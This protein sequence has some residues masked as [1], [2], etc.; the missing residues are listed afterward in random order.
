M[1][2]WIEPGKKYPPKF[3]NVTKSKIG[4]VWEWGGNRTGGRVESFLPLLPLACWRLSPSHNSDIPPSPCL[5]SSIAPF[6]R[7]VRIVKD[8]ERI[9]WSKSDQSLW[10]DMNIDSDRWFEKVWKRENIIRWNKGNG[11]SFGKWDSPLSLELSQDPVIWTFAEWKLTSQLSV[12]EICHREPPCSHRVL[13]CFP[14]T[15]ISGF[16]EQYLSK[17]LLLKNCKIS[18]LS[19]APT[20]WLTSSALFSWLA[21]LIVLQTSQKVPFHD[22]FWKRSYSPQAKSFVEKLK[23]NH[24]II[25]KKR[26]H[27]C[28]INLFWFLSEIQ[29]LYLSEFKYHCYTL[30]IS[31]SWILYKLFI[32]LIH[33]VTET[34]QESDLHSFAK[35][36]ISQPLNIPLLH[37]FHSQRSYLSTSCRV[38]ERILKVEFWQLFPTGKVS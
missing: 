4:G 32:R 10:L 14:S 26:L 20:L 33:A 9:C 24:I 21:L 17:L 19:A 2:L 15:S 38:T 5:K 3:R 8:K 12:R 1:Q 31:I 28:Y 34:S 18:R 35:T 22:Y 16:V 25:S 6:Y 30:S 29:R 11:Q 36:P 37:N 27:S 7:G 23:R 13:L